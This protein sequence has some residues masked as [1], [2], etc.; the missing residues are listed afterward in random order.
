M[1]WKCRML[2]KPRFDELRHRQRCR[3]T[4]QRLVRK[5][6]RAF[7]NRVDV[8]GEAKSDEIV[9]QIATKSVRYS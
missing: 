6:D 7:R 9:D 3:D 8:T 4:D 2:I 1:V 5:T